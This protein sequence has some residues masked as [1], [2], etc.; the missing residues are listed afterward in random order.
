MSVIING[1]VKEIQRT[2]V[3]NRQNKLDLEGGKKD[4]DQG[5]NGTDL[6]QGP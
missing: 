5:N 4:Q 2:V 6:S 1:K 3:P